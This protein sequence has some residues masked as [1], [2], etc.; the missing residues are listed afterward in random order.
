MRTTVAPLPQIEPDVHLLGFWRHLE[1]ERNVSPYTLR[2]YSQAGT[3]FFAW[4]LQVHGR[5]PREVDEAGGRRTL[6][7]C[8]AELHRATQIWPEGQRYFK[9][10]LIVG[11]ANGRQQAIATELN[12][13]AHSRRRAHDAQTKRDRY[14]GL[15]RLRP[16]ERMDICL[17]LSVSRLEL[18]VAGFRGVKKSGRITHHLVNPPLDA[19]S[20]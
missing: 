7:C 16:P 14:L 5:A 8:T 3:E 18:I 4:F 19:L 2:N 9:H 6:Y 20:R 11:D 12:G 10:E 13:P 1:A 17:T 15:H